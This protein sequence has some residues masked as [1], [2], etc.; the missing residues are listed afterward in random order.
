MILLS[1][2]HSFFIALVY[3]FV[4]FLSQ[5]PLDHKLHKGRH[6]SSFQLQAQCMAEMLDKYRLVERITALVLEPNL[7]PA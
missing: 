3:L 5:P 4:V 2:L 6:L 7:I 1:A